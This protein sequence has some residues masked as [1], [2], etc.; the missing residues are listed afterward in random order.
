MT[1]QPRTAKYGDLEVPVL[2]RDW[3]SAPKQP[4]RKTYRLIP[5][6]HWSEAPISERQWENYALLPDGQAVPVGALIAG[7]LRAE[8]ATSAVFTEMWAGRCV[9]VGPDLVCV[10]EDGALAELLTKLR[11]AAGGSLGGL[12]DAIGLFPDGR[13]AMREAK[14]VRARDRIGRKQ[15]RFARLARELLGERFDLAVVE[16]GH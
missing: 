9:L 7:E 12:P 4:Y 3:T 10:R 13:V 6:Q 8:G 2:V 15:H 11:A 14:N 1:S 16:W 5:G